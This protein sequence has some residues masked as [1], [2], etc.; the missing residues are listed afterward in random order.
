MTKDIY[1]FPQ[2]FRVV[3][4]FPQDSYYLLDTYASEGETF[5]S[6]EIEIQ[7][8]KGR[9]PLAPYVNELM[10]GKVVLRT[11]FTAKQYKPALVKPMRVI[12][13]NDLKVRRAGE[14]LYNPDSPDVRAQ[15]LLIEDTAELLSTIDRRKVQQL[16]ETMFTGKTT[17]IGEGVNQELDWD[18]TNKEVLSGKDFSDPTFDVVEYLTEKKM[19]VMS[20]SGLTMRKV[21]TTFEVGSAIVR[22]PTLLA[23]IKAEKET[24]DVGNLN[25]E[26]LPEGVV[27]HGYLRQAAIHIWSYTNS[28]TDEEGK[29]QDYI[30]AGTLALLPDGKPFEFNYGAILIMGE[31]GQFQFVRAKVTP[32]SWTT[33]EPAARYLQMLARPIVVPQNVDGWYVAKVLN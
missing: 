32:Q 9:R 6:D 18:F 8:K 16:S 22:H 2:L 3:E 25:T 30:P 31:N 13:R 4:A 24:L 23:L 12:T 7:T 19:T 14:T 33:R 28:Y 1:A 17:Q 21:L 29:E 5:D 11:G 10:P 20:K 15:K 27:Y 26:L